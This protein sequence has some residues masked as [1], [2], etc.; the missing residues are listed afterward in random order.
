ME[1][2]SD[3]FISYVNYNHDNHHIHMAIWL[4]SDL[5]FASLYWYDVVWENWG[6][7]T[8]EWPLCTIQWKC[9]LWDYESVTKLLC[10][11]RAICLAA[12]DYNHIYLII[13]YSWHKVT[14]MWPV[15]GFSPQISNAALAFHLWQNSMEPR[16]AVFEWRPA[17]FSCLLAFL[18]AFS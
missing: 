9:G 3:I 2:E 5:L 17:L 15:M 16:L 18:P 10:M 1:D 4:K 8:C 7:P 14:H 12:T 11:L 13:I 6:N